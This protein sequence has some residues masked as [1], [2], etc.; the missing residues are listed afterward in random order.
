M[1]NQAHCPPKLLYAIILHVMLSA[2]LIYRPKVSQHWNQPVPVD[3]IATNPQH[4]Q[5]LTK[6]GKRFWLA[7]CTLLAKPC[8][9]GHRGC[10]SFPK[11]GSKGKGLDSALKATAIHPSAKAIWQS[12]HGPPK[13]YQA[14]SRG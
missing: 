10:N 7:D 5:D 14:G 11:G 13:M 1:K 6:Q 8:I 9:Q 4:E 12:H 2:L 3:P